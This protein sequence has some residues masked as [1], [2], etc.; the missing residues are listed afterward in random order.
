[1]EFPGRSDSLEQA[2]EAGTC[3]SGMAGNRVQMIQNLP[4]FIFNHKAMS[5]RRTH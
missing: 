1:M 2:L 3:Q 5:I 4:T